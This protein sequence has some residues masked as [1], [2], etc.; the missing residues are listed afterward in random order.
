MAQVDAVVDDVLRT[1]QTTALDAS[2]GEGFRAPALCGRWYRRGGRRPKASQGGNRGEVG[3]RL[4]SAPMG[5]CEW[6]TVVEQGVGD[7][8]RRV[9][10]AEAPTCG[11]FDGGDARQ[12]GV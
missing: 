12:R 1:Y 3:D 4:A 2:I 11:V 6:R 9:F 8:W 10:S 7:R 5:I